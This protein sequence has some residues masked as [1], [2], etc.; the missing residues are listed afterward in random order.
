MIALWIDWCARNRFLVFTGTLGLVL[1][2][3]LGPQPHT[4]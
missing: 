3:N 2:K 1:A 4:A